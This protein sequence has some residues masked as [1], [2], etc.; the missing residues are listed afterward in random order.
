MLHDESVVVRSVTWAPCVL[1][2]YVHGSSS[3]DPACEQLDQQL[4]ARPPSKYPCSIRASPLAP[5]PSLPGGHRVCDPRGLRGMLFCDPEGETGSVFIVQSL[6]ACN[7]P[8]LPSIYTH[9]YQYIHVVVS[10]LVLCSMYVFLYIA[11]MPC[12][13]S[14]RVYNKN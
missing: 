2:A 6:P 5:A 14:P 9:V 10:I 3:S 8:D 4:A 12:M 7:A 1:H 13:A 11:D